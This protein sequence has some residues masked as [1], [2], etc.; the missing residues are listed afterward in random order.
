MGRPRLPSAERER[1]APVMSY[2]N[3]IGALVANR[4]ISGQL[5]ASLMGGSVVNA[6]QA[7]SP[8]IYAER[9]RRGGD[10]VYYG[11]FEHLAAVVREMGP[12]QLHASL[13]LKR[14]PPGF[15]DPHGAPGRRRR[16]QG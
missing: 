7:L 2:F 4:A 9:E 8:F 13:G 10:E 16:A 1:V 5:V 11:Y 14:L 3:S 12:A 15:A 6:W